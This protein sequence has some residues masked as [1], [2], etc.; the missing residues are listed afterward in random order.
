MIYGVIFHFSLALYLK[1][2]YKLDDIGFTIV[3]SQKS[4]NYIQVVIVLIISQ[5]L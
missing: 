4:Y 3:K 5:Y 2:L 1:L